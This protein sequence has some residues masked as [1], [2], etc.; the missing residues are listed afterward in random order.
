MA[1]KSSASLQKNVI[2]GAIY[3]HIFLYVLQHKSGQSRPAKA[4]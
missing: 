4:K 3:E 1:Q 2:G